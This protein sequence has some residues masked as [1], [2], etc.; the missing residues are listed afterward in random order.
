LPRRLF[1]KACIRGVRA[2]EHM[3]EERVSS[4]SHGFRAGDTAAVPLR[5]IL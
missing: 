4:R 1:S 5:L 2:C 3:L